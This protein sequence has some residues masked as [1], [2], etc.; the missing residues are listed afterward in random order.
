MLIGQ[1]VTLR[2]VRASDL[3]IMRRWFDDADTMAY[4][5]TPR[6]LVTEHEF[7][8]ALTGRFASFCH[9]GYFMIVLPD[10]VP[11]GRIDYEDLDDRNG[12]A[13]LGII[14]G[15]P[16]ARGRGYGP[17]AIVT[18]LRHLFWDRNLHRV[19]LTVLAW[20]ERAIRA[21]RRIGFVDEGVHRDHRFVD[22]AYVDELHMSLLRR[23]FDDRY[24]A[25]RDSTVP[26]EGSSPDQPA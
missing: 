11:V 4:W 2:P 3:P 18:L 22:G 10:D 19:D 21:Y 25:V 7:D 13:S 20:N 12:S 24:G 8:A 14:I 6:P 17:D 5:A 9:A 15:D 1:W 16:D 23:E 26:T